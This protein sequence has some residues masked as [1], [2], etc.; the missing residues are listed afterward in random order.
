[1]FKK[2]D[3]DTTR[4]EIA[5]EL[6]YASLCSAK[7]YRMAQF[8]SNLFTDK[9]DQ[10]HPDFYYMDDKTFLKRLKGFNQQRKDEE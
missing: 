3:K 1:M 5:L 6:T 9:F 2:L 7:G 4:R 10:P 8:I